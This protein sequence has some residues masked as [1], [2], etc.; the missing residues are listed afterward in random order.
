MEEYG[1]NI[2]E[3]DGNP[4][5]FQPLEDGES[6]LEA[7]LRLGVVNINDILECYRGYNDEMELTAWQI[8]PFIEWDTDE[9]DAYNDQE[10]IEAD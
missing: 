4:Y 2:D 8:E 9:I 3:D 6:V 10:R 7:V 5:F 1:D